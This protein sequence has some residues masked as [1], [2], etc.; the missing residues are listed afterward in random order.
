[1]E[2]WQLLLYG[3]VCF[4]VSVLCG[5]AGTGGVFVMMPLAVFLGLTPAQA[6]ATGKIPALSVALGSLS[7]LRGHS[8]ISHW[9]VLPLIV[10][11]LLVG[12]LT[13]LCI[14]VL[15]QAAFRIFFGLLLLIL[16]PVVL[17]KR[18]GVKPSKPSR[19]QRGT[20][21][22]LLSGTLLF[23]GALSG[24]L[25]TLVNVLLVGMLGMTPREANVTKRWSL[26]V[27]NITVIAMVFSSGM[28]DW[29]LAAVGAVTGFAGSYIGGHIGLHK[30]DA[31]VMHVTVF[32]MAVG[33]VELLISA[34]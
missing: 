6:A 17:H 3:V 27:L 20:G 32:L 1:M 14:K 4:G 18:V 22:M 31:F 26:L 21:V 8:R 16:V 19:W 11:A 24:G 29:Q 34:L 13:P 28:I 2:L 9:R 12:L 23:Q 33:G 5:I 15:D 30:G 25:G 7:G 10:L